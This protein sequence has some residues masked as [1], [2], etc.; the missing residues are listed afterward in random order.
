MFNCDTVKSK[1]PSCM[2]PVQADAYFAYMLMHST[3]LVIINI[4]QLAFGGRIFVHTSNISRDQP[5]RLSFY[6]RDYW[7]RGIY[8]VRFIVLSLG[9]WC[10]R[11]INLFIER[12][13]SVVV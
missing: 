12:R 8:I 3:K 2:S 7:L 1:A 9:Y 11:K 4:N 5:N 6:I 10:I 13:D